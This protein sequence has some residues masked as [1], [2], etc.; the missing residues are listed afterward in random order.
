MA[1]V[2]GRELD[3]Q[4][5]PHDLGGIPGGEAANG[6]ALCDRHPV[7]GGDHDQ[8]PLVQP[9]RS[10]PRDD[11]TDDVIDVPD[12]QHVALLV[13]RY[14]PLVVPGE[15]PASPTAAA[16]DDEL[17]CPAGS[18][19]QGWCGSRACRKYSVGC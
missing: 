10:Q 15:R 5:D 16:P 12:L 13:L 8:R 19:T 18:S 2:P 11:P 6:L 9:G 14:L 1:S 7:V 17:R 3:D 4:R